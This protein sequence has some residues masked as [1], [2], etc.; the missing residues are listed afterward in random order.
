MP[1]KVKKLYE[2]KAKVVYETEEPDKL[3]LYFKDTTTAFDGVKKAELKGK[4]S[5][6]NTISSLIFEILHRYGIKTHYIQ[7]LSDNEMLVWKAER[8][9]VEV[10]VRNFA[11][12]SVVKRLGFKEGQRFKE[13]LVEFFYKSDELHDP[14][15]CESHIELMELAPTETIPLMKETALK[16]NEILS[17]FFKEHG[18]TLVDFKLEFGKL[19][20]GSVGIVDEISPDSMRLWD[21]ETGEK[22]DKDRFRFDLGDLLEG[23]REILKRIS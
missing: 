10:V 21:S 8:F 1:E 5:L 7:K 17:G 16:V 4:G 14:L 3:L 12:G 9:P 22:L 19:P 2:G 20:D 15:I 18:I 11:A 23:Y 6:N 13:P